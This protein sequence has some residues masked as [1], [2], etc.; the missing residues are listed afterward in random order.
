MADENEKISV[1]VF[2]VKMAEKKG[3][4]G[5]DIKKIMNLQALQKIQDQFS[6]ATGLAAISVDA[7]GNYITRGSNFTDFCMKYTRG[8]EEGMRRCVKCDN[9]CK[10]TY[11]CHAG[12]MD[13]AAD[14]IVNGEKVG[15]IIGGQVLPQP[16][17]E[18]SFR[19]I[20]RELGIDEEVYIQALRKVPVRSEKM[21]RAA[22]EMLSDVVNQLVNL[23]Y[24]KTSS[25]RKIE[26]FDQEVN[27][28][29]E[30]VRKA[31]LHTKDLQRFASTE[32]LLAINASIEAARAGKAGV[33][34]AVVAREIGELS[35]NSTT[36][37]NEIDELIKRIERS[38]QVMSEA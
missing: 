13:F 14:I 29:L 8:T 38:I 28:A 35:K 26:V 16:P 3:W 24:L 20:A 32:N 7:E 17:D 37:Y 33:G 5:L 21:I 23:E 12:L 22:A 10:G 15:A 9:E 27:S 25:Q 18:E 19:G 2:G 34:F 31:K 1:C 30:A 36:I 11:F 4:N 6:D